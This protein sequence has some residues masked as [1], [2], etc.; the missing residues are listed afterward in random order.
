MREIYTPI[1]RAHPKAKPLAQTLITAAAEQGACLEDF[2]IA[3]Q[4]AL[5]ICQRVTDPSSVVLSEIESQA[6]TAL[7]SI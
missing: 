4:L 1:V 7:E 5:D 6:K 3:C 2:R